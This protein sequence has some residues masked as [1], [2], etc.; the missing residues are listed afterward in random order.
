MAARADLRLEITRAFWV[1]V[2]AREAEQ[3]VARSLD[4][5]GAYVEAISARVSS[6]GS[7]RRTNCCRP[8]RSSRA[9]AWPR[10]KRR[11]ARGVAEADLRRLLGIQ[12]AP[13]IEPAARLEPV[14][15]VSGNVDQF[16]AAA[17]AQR[18]ERR[19]L[20]ERVD[21][22]ALADGGGEVRAASAGRGQRRL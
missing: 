17:I 6:R 22:G 11:T 3:V 10:S 1:L 15:G 20:A 13:T 12:G 14:V 16:I 9:S 8:K 21:G 18:P 4:S 5:I 7:F 19:A 2:T